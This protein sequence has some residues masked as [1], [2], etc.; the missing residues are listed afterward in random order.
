MI[1]EAH[2]VSKILWDFNNSNIER[3]EMKISIYEFDVREKII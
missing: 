2:D 1:I 3:T